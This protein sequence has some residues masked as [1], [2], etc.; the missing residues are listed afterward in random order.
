[1][2][3]AGLAAY[4]SSVGLDKADKLA[5]V[6]SLL[7]AVGALVVPYVLPP[8]DSDHSEQGVVQR[9]VN[10]VV[11]GHLTQVRDIG[12]VRVQGP[13]RSGP[14]RTLP[15]RPYPVSEGE[16]GQHVNG[17]WVGGNLT[18]VDGSDGDVTIG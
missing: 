18:Q 16:G 15:D 2:V 13:P 8:A 14:P 10:S 9:V 3:V 12:G 7:V 6:L 5:S 17:V 4:L 11:G 1:V